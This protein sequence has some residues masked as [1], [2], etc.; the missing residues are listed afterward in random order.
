VDCADF[1]REGPD[2]PFTLQCGAGRRRGRRRRRSGRGRLR[3]AAGPLSRPLDRE[4][5]GRR[6][7]PRVWGVAVLSRAATR[8]SL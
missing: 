6:S 1:A 5:A 3:R 2:E 7:L 8:R 4:P